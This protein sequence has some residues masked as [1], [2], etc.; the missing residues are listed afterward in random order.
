M[1]RSEDRKLG[2]VAE[3]LNEAAKR[4]SREE[5]EELGLDEEGLRGLIEGLSR[6]PDPTGAAL[7]ARLRPEPPPVPPEA[8][9]E[10]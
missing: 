3:A 2:R 5:L 7:N 6:E 4:A 10:S 9:A 8:G 1:F